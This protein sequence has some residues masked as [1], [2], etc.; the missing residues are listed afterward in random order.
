ML[1][2]SISSELENFRYRTDRNKIF[3]IKMKNLY[4]PRNTLSNTSRRDEVNHETKK[5]TRIIQ[6]D[7]IRCGNRNSGREK[8]S[9]CKYCFLN[10]LYCLEKYRKFWMILKRRVAAKMKVAFQNT[11]CSYRCRKIIVHISIIN[12]S[13]ASSITF[14]VQFH[15]PR[16]ERRF[17]KI[18]IISVSNDTMKVWFKAKVRNIL[19]EKVNSIVTTAEREMFKV[20]KI[21]VRYRVPRKRLVNK[22]LAVVNSVQTSRL[23][24][25]TSCRGYTF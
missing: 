1:L 19:T 13:N 22:A 24:G 3:F 25:T 17:P 10:R 21:H 15:F 4:V 2:T 7:Q 6:C 9:A 12:A 20:G 23:F 14:W 11:C 18:I 8:R 16:I 5:S